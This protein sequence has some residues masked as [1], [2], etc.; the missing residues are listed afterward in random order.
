MRSKLS[1]NVDCYNKD[2]LQ[3]LVNEGVIVYE[4]PYYYMYTVKE[5][6]KKWVADEDGH[7]I[8]FI[9]TEFGTEV[10]VLY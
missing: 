4:K 6:K 7:M 1:V 2:E 8:L 5:D 3:E 10:A 9:V